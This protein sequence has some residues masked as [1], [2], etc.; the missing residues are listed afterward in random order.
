VRKAAAAAK[1]IPPLMS[2]N[3]LPWQV[4]E[5]AVEGGQYQY[6]NLTVSMP[7]GGSISRPEVVGFRYEAV[8]ALIHL[9]APSDRRREVF[10]KFRWVAAHALQ[11]ARGGGSNGEGSDS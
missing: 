4:L 7:M 9:M 3:I 2:E 11:A 10:E 5:A 8:L 6:V 1:Q